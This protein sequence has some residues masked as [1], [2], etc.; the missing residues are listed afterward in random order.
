[1]SRRS[2][3]VQ[4]QLALVATVVAI[5]IATFYLLSSRKVQELTT[6]DTITSPEWYISKADFLSYGPDGIIRSKG[7]A[8]EAI[9]HDYNQQTTIESPKLTSFLLGTPYRTAVA[10]HGTIN[11]K[12]VILLTKD[13]VLTQFPSKQDRVLTLTT[14]S[15]LIDTKNN[16]A[17]TSAPV[18]IRQGSGK[19]DAIGLHA[20]LDLNFLSLLSGVHT[21]YA[22]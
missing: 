7:L 14:Q 3:Q 16:T 5:T 12:K 15:L 11:S 18:T 6:A 10:Q 2:R 4:Q 22:P 20:D 8:S 1:M 17:D 21:V 9:H 19:T 13:V